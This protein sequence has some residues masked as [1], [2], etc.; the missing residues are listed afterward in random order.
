[1]WHASASALGWIIIV[2]FLLL[3]GKYIRCQLLYDGCETVAC[4][5]YGAILMALSSIGIAVLPYVVSLI[6]SGV[7]SPVFVHATK[8]S[9]W[10]V[11]APLRGDCC[12]ALC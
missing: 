9:S 8:A 6:V 5:A 4:T 1:M 10:K 2:D 7:N 3:L 12:W 11:R